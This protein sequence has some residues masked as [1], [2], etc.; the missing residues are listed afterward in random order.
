MSRRSRLTL[1]I[2]L[3]AVLA[4]NAAPAA[5]QYT[6]T[7]IAVSGLLFDPF[8]FDV[9]ALNSAGL[10]T[11][12]GA[13]PDPD[14]LGFN[15]IAGI[16]RSNGTTLTTIA[17][18]G[19]FTRFGDVTINAAGQVGFEGTRSQPGRDP[20]GIFRGTGGPV[21]V[22]ALTTPS[23]DFDFVNAGPS[24]D[25]LGRVA[26]IGERIVGGDFVDGVWA[27]DG[28]PVAAIYDDLGA[29]TDF[30]GNPSLNDAGFAAFLAQ[31]GTGVTGLFLGS[32]GAFITVADD[33]GVFT[34][35]FG[36]SDPSLNEAGQ[37]AFRAGTNPDVA[38][39]SGSTAE[40][41]FLYSGGT[42][43]PI[44]EGDFATIAALGDPSLNN[45]GE[46]AF[47]LEPTFG[48]QYLLTG[49]DLAADRVIATGD[50]LFGRTVTSILFGR[51]G[52]NDAGQLA[53]TAFFDDG[54]SAVVLATPGAVV[55]EP[56]TLLLLAG[57]LPL[58]AVAARRRRR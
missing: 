35:A 4:A 43:T 15:P 2:S 57:A 55:P 34:S 30:I 39:N 16:F 42:V 14:P 18:E 31:L 40:G 41:I 8:G 17:L 51:E 54:S 46:V 36:F 33:A 29:F 12:Q 50:V 24:I 9:P 37:V 47:I 25:A 58:V 48:S 56:G 52:L 6:F 10:V 45:V 11:S 21:D 27:G 19:P 1:G 38:D 53:F 3:L 20:Q 13:M 26:F 28:G 32:G 44:V 5:A 22:I 7:P 49:P 23:G